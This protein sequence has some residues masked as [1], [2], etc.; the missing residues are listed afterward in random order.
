MKNWKTNGIWIAAAVL[1]T[2]SLRPVCAVEPSGTPAEVAIWPQWRGPTRDGMVHGAA[3][4]DS[5]QKDHLR[6][7]WRVKL[8]PS[9]SGPIV[10]ADRVFVT[11]TLGAK[12]E[13][14]YALDR[15]TGKELW[16]TSWKGALSV[17][18]FAKSNGDWIRATPAYDGESLYVAGI[19]DVLVCLDAASGAERWRVDF[20]ERFKSQLPAFGFVCSPLVTDDSVF[21]QAGSGFVKLDKRTGET[22]WRVLADEGGMNGSAFSSPLLTEVAGK[23]VVLVQT[24]TKLAAVDAVSGS[25]LWTQEVPAFR[26]MNIL[27]PTVYGGDIFTSTYGGQTALY[28]ATSGA[29]DKA[30]V[31]TTWTNKLQGYMST[32][33]VID[34]HAYLHLRNQRV[35]CVE[36]STG[37]VTW[38]TTPFGK[39]WSLVAN[40]DKILALDERGSLFLIRANTAKYDQID[41]RKISESETWAHLAICG[42]EVFIRSLDAMLAFRWE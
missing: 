15:K 9:Y 31:S 20:V 7:T 11:E 36:M 12:D 26:G 2:V 25:V 19:R 13:V 3:W 17:P 5:L 39:Y 40:G 35:S 4:P 22:R 30:A 29:P 21:V 38:T 42:Q 41:T 23:P 27:T 14:V 18:F 24:R 16:K 6:E 37:K 8:G 33:V 34:G 28:H 10:A 32:P 1:C